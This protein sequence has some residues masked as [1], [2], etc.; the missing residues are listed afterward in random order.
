MSKKNLPD[1]PF[2]S[3][4]MRL[5]WNERST[6]PHELYASSFYA[7]FNHCYNLELW[8]EVK[9]TVR[10]LKKTRNWKLTYK[11][12]KHQ[13]IDITFMCDS[14]WASFA[15]RRTTIGVVGKVCGNV[16]YSICS[17]LKTIMTSSTQGES[18]AIF[19]AAKASR[20]ITNWLMEITVVDVPTF[21]FNDNNAAVEML[22]VRSNSSRS[23]HF[24]VHLKY[25]TQLVEQNKVKVMWIRQG[26]NFADILTHSLARTDYEHQLCLLYSE[27]SIEGFLIKSSKSGGVLQSSLLTLSKVKF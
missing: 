22:R 16:V 25:V 26:E 15:T 18:D 14:D 19:E 11:L 12:Q 10:Y 27:T 24:E 4:V 8:E 7:R 20:Y 1:V 17:L 2:R 5:M 3:T 6:R 23:K 9:K 21:I 13:A